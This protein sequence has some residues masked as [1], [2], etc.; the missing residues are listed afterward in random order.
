MGPFKHFLATDK[1]RL[2]MEKAN[3]EVGASM[4]LIQIVPL[5]P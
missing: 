2:V 1:R 3:E 4:R 5:I